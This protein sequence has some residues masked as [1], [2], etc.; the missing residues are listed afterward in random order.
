MGQYQDQ[1]RQPACVPCG[2]NLSTELDGSNSSDACQGRLQCN[3]ITHT[4]NRQQSTLKTHPE[5]Y[6]IS[7]KINVQ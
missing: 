6:G 7:F 3:P 1:P 5:K 4:T 2:E